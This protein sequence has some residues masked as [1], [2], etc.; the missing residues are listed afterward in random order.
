MKKVITL[1]TFMA[2]SFT[3][4]QAQTVPPS[5]PIPAAEYYQGGQ[6]ALYSFINQNVQY[7]MMAKR[8]RIQGECIIHL[9]IKPDGSTSNF[10]V[11]QNKGGGTG[12]EALRVVKLLKFRAPGYQVDVNIPVIFKL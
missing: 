9:I 8:N 1:L 10:T 11:V 12:E 7:P 4:L 5:K 2:A 3:G 6:T